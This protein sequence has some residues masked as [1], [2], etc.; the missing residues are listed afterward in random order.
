MASFFSKAKSAV[1]KV[2]NTV[3]NTASKALP[4]GSNAAN[5][6]NS[7][8]R[9]IT[10]ST[11]Q[12]SKGGL[13]YSASNKNP[14]IQSNLR[15][16]VTK[17]TVAN[18]TMARGSGGIGN[19]TAPSS[20]NNSSPV[21]NPLQPAAT[22]I[23]RVISSGSNIARG[24]GRSVSDAFDGGSD[25][26]SGGD[27]DTS[28]D[29]P[30]NYGTP[31]TINGKMG[32]E[33]VV[34]A[35][36]NP[37]GAGG[38]LDEQERRKAVADQG[39]IAAQQRTDSQRILQEGQALR[40]AN[41]AGY[42]N[43]LAAQEAAAAALPVEQE[44]D[45]TTQGADNETDRKESEGQKIQKQIDA[46]RKAMA[47]N[48]ELTSE[49]QA[50]QS[51]LDG[52]D[53]KEAAINAQVREEQAQAG[54]QPVAQGFVS[55]WQKG[56]AEKGNSALETIAAQKIPLV[57]R[58]AQ[59]QQRRQA[60]EESSRFSLNNLVDQSDRFEKKRERKQD[61]SY[62]SKKDTED[63]RRYEQ[64]RQDK[65]KSGQ[66]KELGDGVTLWDTINNRKVV[67]TPKIFAPQQPSQAPSSYRE[68]QLAGSP[69]TYATF[70]DRKSKGSSNLPAAWA[71]DDQ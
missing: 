51:T 35:G 54:S 1:G 25:S 42:Q 3:L 13:D 8:P 71:I 38:S 19:Y 22:A 41:D 14:V 20:T 65:I 29:S 10:T 4:K 26:A 62:R 12:A 68:W 11:S 21:S 15:N 32:N 61:I 31:T 47:K 34:S 46:I 56:L 48:M 69:G 66:Y 16:A 60:A 57:Q 44:E 18:N 28:Y 50:A 55:G 70:L 9:P 59:A 17:S 39:G 23:R 63:A 5:V 53:A 58:I 37:R 24:V 36:Y 64:D 49:D 7:I 27:A 33:S 6:L 43:D 45:Y 52:F 2:A 30:K 40:E 67:T